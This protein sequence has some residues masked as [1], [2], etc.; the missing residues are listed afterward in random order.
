M[1]NN[2]EGLEMARISN[3]G[4]GLIFSIKVNGKD[5]PPN[6][7]SEIFLPTDKQPFWEFDLDDE[8]V[9]ATG[10]ITVKHSQN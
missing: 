6:K 9:L 7:V 8:I 3:L 4:E 2:K 1:G 10:N 5:I